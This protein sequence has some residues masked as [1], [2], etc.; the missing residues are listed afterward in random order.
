MSFTTTVIRKLSGS[1]TVISEPLPEL[2]RRDMGV[3]WLPYV[4]IKT[5]HGRITTIAGKY[6][7]GLL[8]WET[9]EFI[10]VSRKRSNYERREM[11]EKGKEETQER[12]C[13]NCAD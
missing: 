6:N 4:I 11:H 7:S 3:P 12:S 1:V 2:S 9:G 10:V 13:N 5:C 8:A